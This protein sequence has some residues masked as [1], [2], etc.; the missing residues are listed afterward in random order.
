[1][2]PS[3]RYPQRE[4]K[5]AQPWRPT[6]T[7]GKDL[8]DDEWASDVDM[9]DDSDEDL[10]TDDSLREFIASD[11]SDEELSTMDSDES[12]DDTFTLESSDDEWDSDAFVARRTPSPPPR[13]PVT[14]EISE[15]PQNIGN[16]P[17]HPARDVP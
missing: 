4:R 13:P 11:E 9:E 6:K 8:K 15:H 3:R 5:T 7:T 17:A 10:G 14:P 2:F 1:M 16:V 12:S